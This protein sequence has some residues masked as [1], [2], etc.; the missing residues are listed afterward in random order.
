MKMFQ[1][2]KCVDRNK[3]SI[4]VSKQFIKITVVTNVDLNKLTMKF[5]YSKIKLDRNET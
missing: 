3:K 4:Y 5:E 1:R 2:R